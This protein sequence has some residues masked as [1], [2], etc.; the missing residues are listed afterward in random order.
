MILYEKVGSGGEICEGNTGYIY[1]DSIT[2]VKCAACKTNY[3]RG[4]V[5]LHQE[6]ALILF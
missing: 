6:S 3:F 5:G 1:E 2:V 4:K